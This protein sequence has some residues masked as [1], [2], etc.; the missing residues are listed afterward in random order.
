MS[1]CFLTPFF[2]TRCSVGGTGGSCRGGK[3]CFGDG[4]LEAGVGAGAGCF[5]E[6]G[7]AA[8][9][10]A[11]ADS[12]GGGCGADCVVGCFVGCFVGLSAVFSTARA[13]LLVGSLSRSSVISTLTFLL[14]S[15]RFQSGFPLKLKAVK[16]CCKVVG[17]SNFFA[18]VS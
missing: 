6:G 3:G 1:G 13:R 12:L 11:G 9:V 7:L 4:G 14:P 10:G 18:I 5:G 8:G 17:N 15:D 2:T 16:A